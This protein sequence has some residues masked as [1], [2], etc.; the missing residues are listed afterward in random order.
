MVV[1]TNKKP[2]EREPAFE[3][4]T[5]TRRSFLNRIW[6]GLGL[7]ALAELVWLVV[8]FLRPGKPKA[9]SGDFGAVVDCGAVEG[10]A[11]GSV[12]AFPRGRFYLCRLE[13]GGFLALSRQCTHL[14]C[15]VPWDDEAKV[16]RCPCH[17][18]TFDITGSVVTSPA[19]RAL[20]LYPV[21]I[22]NERVSVDTGRSIKRG[23]FRPEQAVY[24]KADR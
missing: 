11:K 8:S 2:K 3:S 20:D 18:S 15:T 10:F 6:A 14:G 19:P 13:D 16:F 24:A 9:R 21:T 23:D 12:A 7:V 17:G 1:S 5:A 4:G 22:E